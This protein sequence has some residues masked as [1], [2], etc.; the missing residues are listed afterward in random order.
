MVAAACM[1]VVLARNVRDF[2]KNTI[3]RMRSFYG[4]L[5]VRQFSNW[6]K[7]PYRT[8]YNGKIEH[9][10][11]YVNSPQNLLPTTYYG[12]DSGVG[13]ALMHCCPNAKRV[14][15][16]GLGAGTLAAYGKTSDHFRFYEINPQVV[17]IAQSSFSY[18]R[19]SPARVDVVL[20]DARL[21]LQ[22]EASQQFDVLAVDAFSGDAIPV[23]LLTREAFAL[24]LR[25]LKPDGILAV[26]TSNSY[27]NLPPVVQLLAA[28][29]G[30]EAQLITNDH[31]HRK[32]IDSADWVL[33]TRNRRF[34]DSIDSTV[35]IEE[36]SVPPNLRVWTDDFNNLFQILRPVRFKQSSPR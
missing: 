25:H 4:A 34:L 29:A 36:I 33:V 8:L 10:A 3:V 20:G 26:H 28:D 9:G 12:P 1:V 31:E 35:M 17:S 23:H 22:S 24:Y 11:Q 6:L 21:S 30:Y 13:L 32:L 2:D 14:G 5:R 27:L 16:I 19:D 7:E 18:L 15:A